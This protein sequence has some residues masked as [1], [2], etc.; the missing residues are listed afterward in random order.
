MKTLTV[1]QPWAHAIMHAGKDVENRTWNTKHRGP[2]LIHAGKAY[3][4]DGADLLR[5]MGFE[6]DDWVMP[7]GVILG[8]V[9][10]V[11]VVQDSDSDWAQDG[12]FHWKLTAPRLFHRPMSRRGGLGLW[13]VDMSIPRRLLV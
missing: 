9:Q 4:H 5:D 11:D 13:N 7:G 6:P 12:C 2:L 3:D 8:V 10:L 1:K